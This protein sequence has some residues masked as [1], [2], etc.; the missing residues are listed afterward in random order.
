[1]MVNNV[2]KGLTMAYIIL[3]DV[4]AHFDVST[5][6]FANNQELQ[7]EIALLRER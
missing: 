2:I 6:D 3:V 1:M 7:I 4:C 5:H